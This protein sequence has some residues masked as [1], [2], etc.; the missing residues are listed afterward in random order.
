MALAVSGVLGFMMPDSFLRECVSG[1]LLCAYVAA[2]SLDFLS[3]R[4]PGRIRRVDAMALCATWWTLVGPMGLLFASLL[5]LGLQRE[6]VSITLISFQGD[7][8]TLYVAAMTLGPLWLL[9][10]NRLATRRA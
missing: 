6:S 9:R 1:L 2:L 10:A 8:G 7:W 5:V 4:L 3:R